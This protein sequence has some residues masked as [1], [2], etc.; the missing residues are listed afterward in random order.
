MTE[1]YLKKK[2]FATEQQNVNNLNIHKKPEAF[3][4]PPVM[5]LH[6]ASPRRFELPTPRL[7]EAL[8]KVNQLPSVTINIVGKATANQLWF[9]R[10][11]F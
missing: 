3:K 11:H 1:E 6:V 8:L 7:G 9:T 5:F 2:I 4:R 10:T